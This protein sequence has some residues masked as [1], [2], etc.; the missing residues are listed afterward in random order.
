LVTNPYESIVGTYFNCKDD[1]PQPPSKC[2]SMTKLPNNNGPY[3]NSITGEWVCPECFIVVKQDNEDEINDLF[4]DDEEAAFDNGE[5]FVA[6]GD[7][8]QDQ[9]QE[10]G[11]RVTRLR[12]I[13][14]IV[15]TLQTFNL[16]FARYMTI[17]NY[18]IVDRLRLLEESQEDG[19]LAGTGL[20]INVKLLAITIDMSNIPL[21][22]QEIR[23]L[24]ERQSQVEARLKVLKTLKTNSSTLSPIVQKIYYV[25]K[26]IGLSK[27]ILDIM[28]E[29]Y[30]EASPLPNREPS[31]SAR[32]AA[33]I[34]I[35]AKDSGI[36]GV[37]KKSLK[38]VPT[39]KSAELD[40]AVESYR[41]V[42]QKRI[43]PVEGVPLLDVD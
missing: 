1:P 35:K 4:D 31:E 20:G 22:A 12:K 40:R 5:D 30:E 19:F 41:D 26:S 8:I 24:G 21:K 28:V 25:G 10:E 2:P 17:N 38:S 14:E 3:F 16:P 27:T 11:I 6:E 29:Q 33:W 18:A 7:S 42:I 34:F 39:V 9:S 43:K 23:L 13:D 37:T 15:S 36:K 32:A